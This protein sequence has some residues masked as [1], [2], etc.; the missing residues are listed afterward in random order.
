[1]IILMI[2]GCLLLF[3]G[4]YLSAALAGITLTRKNAL[5]LLSF[6]ALCGIL[7]L[8][9]L[10]FF[11]EGLLW[12]VYPLVTHIPLILLYTFVFHKRVATSLAAVSTAYLCCQPSKWFGILSF[13]I[14]QNSII[15]YIVRDSVLI[16]VGYITLRYLASYL[17]EIFNKETSNVYIFGIVPM[18]YYLFDYATVIYTNLWTTNNRIV[19]EFLPFFLCIIF[20]IFCFVYHKEYEQ[21]SD[22]MRKEQII[23]ITADQQT[24]E[25]ETMKQNE[26]EIRIL[27]H[28]MRLFLS[29]LAVCIENEEPSHA[30][31]MISS[32]T[33]HIDGTKLQH[34]CKNDTINYVLSDFAAKCKANDIP[35]SYTIKLLDIPKDEILFLSILSNALDNALNAQISLPQSSRFIDLMLK[36]SNEKLLLSVK[37]RITQC[38]D[39]KDGI[40]ITTRDGH[41]YGVKSIQYMT[42]RL[43]GNS[44]FFVQDDTFTVR[45]VI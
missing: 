25:L 40:P 19:A 28:D 45:V 23:Q 42:E 41:G 29:S 13:S 17:S 14:I 10:F 39:F 22:A 4:I 32:F 3:F 26:K 35:F 12:K 8:L 15:E 43:H 36:N 34:F 31:E 5:S 37:N 24:R 38:P 33:S 44:Q 9:I 18:T 27:R 21:K 30:L 7:Q 2:H 16:I 11:S 6:G 1:M 20:M